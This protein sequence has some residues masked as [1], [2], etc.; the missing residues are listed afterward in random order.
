MKLLIDNEH[1]AITA[2]QTGTRQSC[3]EEKMDACES[4]M[5]G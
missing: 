2:Q 5:D 3:L 1:T 4:K